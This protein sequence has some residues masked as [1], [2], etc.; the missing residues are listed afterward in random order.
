[1]GRLISLALGLVL[2]MGLIAVAVMRNA[3]APV[4]GLAE[5]SDAPAVGQSAGA[6]G[7]GADGPHRPPRN[8]LAETGPVDASPGGSNLADAGG[9]AGPIT[10]S[11]ISG[12]S[13]A[14]VLER[15]GSG[16]FHLDA[17][18]NGQSTQFLV[19]TGADLV[20]LT[21][22]DAERL[23]VPVDPNG[24]RPIL[25]TASGRGLGER[26][27]IGRLTIGGRSLF[28]VDAVVAQG[29]GVNLLGQSVLRRLGKIE[30]SGDVMRISPN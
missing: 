26:V 5:S 3:P 17:G 19:D 4:A 2:V 12:G 8:G 21:P 14:L 27:K 1:M 13:R 6:W 22:E 28:D 7:K 18:V 20:S 23:G 16:Q 24:F 15:D 10:G 11:A 25:R 29:L 30:L 9:G